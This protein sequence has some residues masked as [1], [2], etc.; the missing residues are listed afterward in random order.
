M[1]TSKY[2]YCRYFQC[3]FLASPILA[4]T[5]GTPFSFFL[6]ARPV[7]SRRSFFALPALAWPPAPPTNSSERIIFRVCFFDRLGSSGRCG[8]RRMAVLQVKGW[9]APTG[10]KGRAKMSEIPGPGPLGSS[11]SA[12]ERNTGHCRS[13]LLVRFGR[14]LRRGAAKYGQAVSHRNDGRGGGRRSDLRRLLHSAFPS[15]PSPGRV[16]KLLNLRSA[17]FLSS[18]TRPSM[19]GTLPTT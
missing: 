11:G 1:E 15:I 16:G 19:N 12:R 3:D 7:L 14:R 6:S 9:P 5:I 4:A 18:K 8:R 13:F 10:A 17:I 2:P